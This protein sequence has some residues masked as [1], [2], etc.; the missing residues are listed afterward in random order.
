MRNVRMT[1]AYVGTRFAGWQVQPGRP[2][3]QGTLEEGLS[4]MLQEQV[5]VAGAGRTDAGVHALGQVA[6]FTTLRE[7]PLHGLRRG[8][9][10][11][12]PEDIRV[13]E[14]AEAAP[15]FHARGDA[16]S[17]EYR[18]RLSRAEV[19]SPF[20]APFVTPVRGRLDVAAMSRAARH[21]LGR[22]DFTSFCPAGCEQ[23]NRV[24]VVTLARLEES[25]DEI[26]FTIRAGG[27]LRH[28][29]RTMVGTLLAV[30]AGRIAPDGIEG[31]LAAR[32]RRA[33]GPCAPARGLTLMRV[34]YETE[35]P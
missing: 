21:F 22:H 26:V 2:T 14:A 30:G 35:G 28:M 19:V 8:L 5:A 32:D 1:L 6:S 12:L 27:F 23:E 11:R 3:I 20:E 4:R 31:I 9:N 7:L 16:R 13:L 10:A 25:G 33:A 24:R 34:F 17:K 29:I 15:G 18:Y